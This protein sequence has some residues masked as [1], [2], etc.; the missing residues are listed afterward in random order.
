MLTR[1]QARHSSHWQ[2]VPLLAP[3]A[4]S[5]SQ[6]L[7]P[8]SSPGRAMAAHLRQPAA[9]RAPA[10]SDSIS[11]SSDSSSSSRSSGSSCPSSSCSSLEMVD[12]LFH[13]TVWQIN[14]AVASRFRWPEVYEEQQRSSSSQAAAPQHLARPAEQPYASARPGLH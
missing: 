10:V 12:P 8:P 6:L 2:R 14:S 7:L 4:V 3:A 9:T 13:S 5:H 11:A 1:Q